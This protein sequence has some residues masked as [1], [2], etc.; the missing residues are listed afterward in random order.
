MV[1]KLVL[2][3]T[4]LNGYTWTERYGAAVNSLWETCK[5]KGLEA[6]KAKWLDF[7]LFCSEQENPK[8]YK[9][10]K[11]IIDDYSGIHF[12]YGV[13]ACK[14]KT[15]DPP[16]AQRLS[17]IYVSTFVI[18]GERDSPD[19]H[20]IADL[21]MR[22]I[23]LVRKVVIPNVKHMSNMEDPETF[24]KEILSFLTFPQTTHQSH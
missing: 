9:A 21:L 19:F 7:E 6:T 8:A 3:D 22:D 15:K 17:D 5:E 14:L 20:I 18:I 2:V 23:P 12:E 1:E 24:N 4:T 10:L 16:M 11:E 13:P